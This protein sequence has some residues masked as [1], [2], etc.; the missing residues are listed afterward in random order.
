M[1]SFADYSGSRPG[2]PLGDTGDSLVGRIVRAATSGRRVTFVLG[3]DEVITDWGEVHREARGMAADLQARGVRPGDHVALLSP[4]TRP[5]V[6]AIQATWLAGATLVVLPLPM[7]LG[8]IEEF[9]AQTRQRIHHADAR[10]VIVDAE[11]APF[12]TPEPDDPPMVGFGDLAGDP[13]AWVR[14]P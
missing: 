4:T 10:L 1:P 9:I 12:V 2:D 5:L 13:D 8:S 14:P 3:G 7:R 6:A 11:L